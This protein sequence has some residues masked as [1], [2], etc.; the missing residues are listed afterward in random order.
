MQQDRW[1]WRKDF[2][3]CSLLGAWRHGW[4]GRAVHP[5]P[6]DILHRYLLDYGSAQTVKQVHGRRIVSVTEINNQV[7]VADGLYSSDP[8]LSVWVCSADCVPI[9]LGDRRGGA[10]MAIHAGWRGTGA[11]ILAEALQLLAQKGTQ[12]EDLCIGLGPAIS[13]AVYQVGAEVVSQVLSIVKQPVGVQ[14]DLSTG[15]R[16]LLDLRAVQRQFFLEAGV[17]PG[18]IGI[19][20]Y[21]TYQ[22]NHLF[23]SYRRQD[24]QKVQWAGICANTIQ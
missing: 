15:D 19:A 4:F 24:Y 18:Q 8:H 20:P 17:P 2:L 22:Q 7:V 9:L 3:T 10:V 1:Q 11:G 16:Y 5:H 23:F 14:P 21:C 12:I 13:G 6:P